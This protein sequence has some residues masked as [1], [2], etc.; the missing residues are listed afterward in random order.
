LFLRGPLDPDSEAL[1]EGASGDAGIGQPQSVV[2]LMTPE[3]D[4]KLV[5]TSLEKKQSE[6][7]RSR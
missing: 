7:V 5:T 2:L 1:P 6:P 4:A 3:G